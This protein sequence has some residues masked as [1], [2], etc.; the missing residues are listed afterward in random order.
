[1]ATELEIRWFPIKNRLERAATIDSIRES[2][3]Q[4]PAEVREWEQAAVQL[5]DIVSL[6]NRWH[7][8]LMR[9]AIE[10][11][12]NEMERD[13]W[14]TPAVPFCWLLLGSSGRCEST[15]HP[16]QDHALLYLSGDSPEIQTYFQELADRASHNL[17]EI[18]Y[19][20]CEG[21]VMAA[22]PRW[23]HNLEEWKQVLFSYLEYP[24]WDNIRYLLMAAD[25]RGV[26]GD[27]QLA[28]QLRQ[29]LAMKAQPHSYIYWQA[30]DRSLSGKIALT[31]FNQFRVDLWGDHMHQ[32]NIKEGG[33]LQIVKATRLW[34]MSFGIDAH[35]T[36]ERIAELQKLQIWDDGWTRQVKDALSCFMRHRIWSNYVNPEKLSEQQSSALK[37]ALKTTKQLQKWTTKQFR[38]TGEFGG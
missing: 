13:G 2:R 33:Y 26:Y 31:S 12:L 17:A 10:I 11:A 3:Q 22:N 34:A 30:A 32:V 9:R 29:W 15:L 21:F 7:D 19:P 24:N 27:I 38:R 35:S 5:N 36:E 1:M 37:Q 14:G 4:M 25:M 18:G 20:Y 6:I 8:E 28:E 16:D 23:N